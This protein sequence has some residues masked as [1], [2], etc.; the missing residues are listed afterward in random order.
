LIQ[1]AANDSFGSSVSNAGDING[2]G[3]DDLIIGADRADPNGNNLA[4][5]SY[6]VFG[7]D[8]GLPNPLNGA[9]VFDRSGGSVSNAGDING[10]GIDDLIIGARFANPND[11]YTG[12]SY[13]VFGSDT[14]LPN[15]LIN[16]LNGF[17]IN[18][19]AASDNS[20]VSVSAAGDI[21]G[22]GIDDLV[23][24]AP[25]TDVNGNKIAGSSYVVFGADTGLSN[26]LN[27]A[28]LNGS[29]G[30]TINGVADDRSGFSVSAAGDING[31][32]IDDLI[33]GAFGAGPNGNSFAGRS[34]VVFGAVTG[35]PNPLNLDDLN[36][37]NGFTI[38]GVAANDRSGFS[39]SA[40]GDINGDG[41]DD[42]MIGASR[43]DPNGINDAG[44]SYVV[45][46]GSNLPHPFDL[47]TL[48]GINGFRLDGVSV[49]DNSGRSVSAAGDINGDGIDDLII[50][51]YGADSNGN[52]GAG[53][54][55]VVYEPCQP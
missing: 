2:D 28:N 52:I 19:V 22:D 33:I 7:S 14:G 50:G 45:F 17:T 27:L 13:V 31:D 36:G 35:L 51:A 37:S 34:Y 29:N 38:N 46:G 39:V 9:T 44:S 32:G 8:T 25:F 43:A 26:P 40:A 4:G 5:S 24:G 18:G 16:G 12:S 49:N 47:S 54:S 30:F 3:I 11:N 20:G 1:L 53:S 42:L 23:V 41:I 48:N 21:N 10:D 55:Y 6:V 15:P